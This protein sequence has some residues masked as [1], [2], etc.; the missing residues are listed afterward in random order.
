[1]IVSTLA[2]KNTFVKNSKKISFEK[3]HFKKNEMYKRKLSLEYKLYIPSTK[4][5]F[6]SLFANPKT[7][8]IEIGSWDNEYCG[9]EGKHLVAL[10]K[11]SI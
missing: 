6:A 4:K 3:F 1:M 9:V 8:H 2:M 5:S 7:E 10:I 11:K